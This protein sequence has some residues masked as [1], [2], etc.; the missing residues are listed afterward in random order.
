MRAKSLKSAH[1]PVTAASG[2]R[3]L[4]LDGRFISLEIDPR[5]AEIIRQSFANAGVGDRTEVRVGP[6]LELLPILESEAPFDLVFIDAD[7]PSYPHYLEWALR[8][9]RPGSIIVADNT[10]RSLRE[11][12]AQ[13]VHSNGLRKYNQ[14]ASS[15]AQLVSLALPINHDNTDGFTISVVRSEEGKEQQTH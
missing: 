14:L 8:L 15:N 13:D 4:P 5:H 1:W 3:A 6:A 2:W 10:V 7:K 11:T 9:T 12:N